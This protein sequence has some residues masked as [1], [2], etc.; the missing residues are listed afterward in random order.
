DHFWDSDTGC[1][2]PEAEPTTEFQGVYNSA[3]TGESCLRLQRAT[4]VSL[5]GIMRR[6]TVCFLFALLAPADGFFCLN[7]TNSQGYSCSTTRQQCTSAVNGCI[8]I[9]R[10]E[11]TGHLG[12]QNPTYEKK[13][14]TDDRLCDQVYGLV[15]GDFSMHWNSSCCRSDSCNDEDIIVQEASAVPN[16]V[17]CNSCFAQGTDVCLN[18]T[19]VNCTGQLDQCIHFV[20]IAKEVKYKDQQ[21]T[22][23]GCATE[24]MCSIGA[25]ALFATGCQVSVKTI[26]CSAAPEVPSQHGLALS[27]LAGLLFLVYQS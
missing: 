18:T 5:I 20:T 14:N 9:A 23:K 7:C 11:D 3:E 21:V 8:T 16:G 1:W 13:C 4:E 24:N 26:T 22:F 25:I 17:S 27:A 12:I 10:N 19:Q 15:A 6:L 2:A